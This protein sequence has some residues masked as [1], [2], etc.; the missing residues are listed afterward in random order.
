MALAKITVR[1]IVQGVG[2]R[3]F[4]YRLA[5]NHGLN[6]YVMNAI[7][8]V[9]IEVEGPLS[10]IDGFLHDVVTKKPVL[11]EIVN[12]QTEHAHPDNTTPRH[13]V[14]TV[15]ESIAA[16]EKKA[17][18]TP[19]MDVCPDCLSELMDPD[20][21]RFRYP[22]I[23]CASCGPRYTIIEDIPYDRSRT[24]MNLFPMCAACEK[25]YY[26]PANRRFHAEATAC[27]DCGPT[28]SL[29][30]KNGDKIDTEPIQAAIELLRQGN[31]LAVKGIGGFH[32]AVDAANESAIARLRR[33]KTR[34]EKPLAVMAPDPDAAATFALFNETEKKLLC[35]RQKPIVILRK[36]KT[37]PLA[38]NI[39]PNNL[40]IGVMLPYTPLHHLLLG[41]HSFT[42]LIMT[43]GNRSGEPIIKDNNDALAR[44]ATIT[45]YFL[46]HNRPIVTRNDDS[47]TK[48]HG[49]KTS[50]IRRARSYAP[51]P[52]TLKKDAGLTL[53]AGGMLKNV[54]CLTRGKEAFVSQHIGDLEHLET[55]RHF[56]YSICHLSQLLRIQPTLIVHDLHPDYLSTRYAKEQTELPKVSVQHH[57]A[58]AVSCMAE[59]GLSGPVIAVTLDGSG[60]GADGTIWGGEVLLASLDRFEHAAHLNQ[61]PMPGGEIAVKEPWRMAA[62]HLFAAFG[63]EIFD[64][65]LNLVKEH[66]DILPT[67]QQMTE[68]GINSPLTSSCGRFFDAI[69]A[70][71]GIRQKISYEGQAAVELESACLDIDDQLTYPYAIKGNKTGPLKLD[72][73][74]ITRAVTNEILQGETPSRIGKRFHNTL[75]AMFADVCVRLR[76]IHHLD[77]VVLSGGVFQN[78]TLCYSLKEKLSGL[79]FKVF[80][81]QLVPTN[82]G[83]LALGQA[84]AGRAIYERRGA[85]ER[86]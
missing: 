28:L 47:V 41:R 14:F 25:E 53:A 60:Y 64:L 78:I 1:G 19:D 12:L 5:T 42:A 32:L 16:G 6:G 2:F 79:G 24:S 34:P 54:F 31:I 26:D 55:L 59:H 17:L 85:D 50:F 58:H 8:G 70:I 21:R 61:V 20:D 83:G 3:P 74:P 73:R 46:M 4:I 56:E 7:H 27:F 57:H 9:D 22:F 18:V 84:V 36:K 71:L 81:H 75:A 30:N 37:F 51:M 52:L 68:K 72:S 45:D 62:S 43:S 48:L 49:E 80:T 69:A 29:T 11:A 44:M 65:D 39:V 35:G 10:S 40:F 23:N 77:Q 86:D 33:L 63:Q 15:Q 67:L 66:S 82:D 13:Q 76:E 38:A